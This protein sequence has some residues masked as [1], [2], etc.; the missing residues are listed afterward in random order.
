M[1]PERP[2]PSRRRPRR[3]LPLIP[4][5]C[6]VLRAP[7]LLLLAALLPA[8]APNEVLVDL[9]FCDQDE[10]CFDVGGGG[11]GGGVTTGGTDPGAFACGGVVCADAIPMGRCVSEWLCN[12]NG[13]CAATLAAEAEY[14]DKNPCTV[15][16][17]GTD[18]HWTHIPLTAAELDDGDPC[19]KD[20]C[21]S[22]VGILH[23]NTC[24]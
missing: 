6:P 10:P 19:T 18:G 9:A 22:E 7:F 12:E 21:H 17:C 23:T 13:K 14:Q 16:G 3:W 5:G 8:C 20:E 11:S 24:G 2:P 4:R 1:T 15:D